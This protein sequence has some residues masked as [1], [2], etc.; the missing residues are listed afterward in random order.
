MISWILPV[1][2]GRQ[3]LAA[4]VESALDE[5]GSD[6]EVIVVDDGSRDRPAEVLP[7]DGRVRLLVQPP[8]GIAAAL[9][10]GRAAARGE[11]LARL[12]A[13]DVALPGRIAA[14]VAALQA[15]PR[16]GAVGGRAQIRRDDGPVPEGM[17]RYVEWVNGLDDLHRALLVESPLLHPAVT[18]RAQAVREVGGWRSF[19]GPEDYDLWLRMAPRWRLAAVPREV[20]LLR[21]RPGRLTRTDP[22]YRRRAF[23]DLKLAWLDRH[24]LGALGP[25]P[26]VVIWGAGRT[27]RPWIRHLRPHLVAVIDLH[28]K[29]PRQGVP[30][31]APAALRDL[32]L[33]LLLVAVG[34]R[35]AR[36]AI[37]ARLAELRPDLVEG[38]DWWAVA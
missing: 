20:V 34:V 12:D 10:T 14:Q 26:R 24:V 23:L 22:R 25:S 3:W 38:R 30:V 13:D 7:R 6:D 1:R 4:A 15:D 11:Y 36:A 17:R 32:E 27:G 31:R 35:G 2:D 16:L 9:E 33:D 5:C 19:D 8:R 28:P 21:D 37:R 18:L 29:G